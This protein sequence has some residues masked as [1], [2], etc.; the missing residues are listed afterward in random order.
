MALCTL[1]KVILSELV[2]SLWHD[3]GRNKNLFHHDTE[4]FTANKET[5]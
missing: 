4:K 1:L 3:P 5:N 2:L